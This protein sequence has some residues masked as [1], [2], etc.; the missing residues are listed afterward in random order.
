MPRKTTT[1]A[2]TDVDLVVDLDAEWP[3]AVAAPERLEPAVDGGELTPP[4]GGNWLREADGGL[5]PRDADTARA[6]GLHWPADQA[7]A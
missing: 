5:R 7:A 6:A 4:C 1:A 2:A 3:D